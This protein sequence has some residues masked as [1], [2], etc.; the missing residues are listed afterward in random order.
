MCTTIR[1][2]LPNEIAQSLESL[3]LNAWHEIRLRAEKKVCVVIGDSIVKLD[4]F[5]N[6][7]QI[8]TVLEKMCGDSVY[9]YVDEIANGYIT[10]EGGHRVGIVGRVV[11]KNNE[12]SYVRNISGLNIRYAKEIIGCANQ[13]IHHIVTPNRVFNT[14]IVAPPL[15][16]KTTILRDVVR[17]ISDGVAAHPP[18][19]VAI[20]DERGEIAAC[21]GGV[22]QYMVGDNT[23]VLDNCP[24]QLGMEMLL[25]SMSP[26]VIATDELGNDGDCAAVCSVLNAGVK[27][28]ATAHGYAADKCRGDV[29]ELIRRKAFEKIIVLSN[30][31]GPGTIEEVISYDD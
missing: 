10:L 5:V 28:I 21:T 7:K 30:K 11:M 25:R 19:N 24:K 17:Q 27:I 31:K 14:L 12:V 29:S 20:V 3:K 4:C 2:F 18:C 6:Q 15:C 16:G 26:T 22:P 13:I 9:A 8:R 1:R 23:D